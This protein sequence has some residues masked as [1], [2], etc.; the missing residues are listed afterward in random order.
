MSRCTR[1]AL[2][3]LMTSKLSGMLIGL[4]AL[5]TCYG[6]T[7]GPLTMAMLRQPTYTYNRY[8]VHCGFKQDDFFQWLALLFSSFLIGLIASNVW[9]V[10]YGAGAMVVV[11]GAGV[12]SGIVR[13][14]KCKSPLLRSQ[15]RYNNTRTPPK[16]YIALL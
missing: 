14:C 3:L 7:F 5:F 11:A 8:C 2:S 15:H 9:N 1:P 10:V 13:L 4:R 12:V 16:L 6:Y